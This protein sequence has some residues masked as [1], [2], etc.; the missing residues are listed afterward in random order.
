M[1]S[2]FENFLIKIK[3]WH[4]ILFFFLLNIFFLENFPF[5]HSD[6]AWLSGLSR[7][8]MQT[9][10][11]SSTESFFDLLPRHPHAV[12]IFFHLLQILFIKISGYNIFTFRL[13]S[14]LS[15]SLAAFFF[16]KI[17]IFI[18]KSKKL[19]LAALLI[20]IADIHFIYSSHL[21]RQEAVLLFIFLAALYYF[22]KYN[23][24]KNFKKSLSVFKINNSSSKLNNNSDND[25]TK[26]F[27]LAL[28][29]G[30]AIGFHPN[31]FIIALPFI[32][33]Y[34]CRLLSKK[35]SIKNYLIFGV[36][37]SLIAGLFIYFSFKLD[38]DFISNYSSYGKQL[39]V[40][41][42][43]LVKFKN[44]KNFYLKLYYR[45]SGTYYIPP[46]KFQLI[47]FA[48][49]AIISLFKLFLKKDKI[50]FYLFISLISINI[51]YLIIG[52]YNQ[53]SIIFIFPI[54]YLLFINLI[55]N[56]NLNLKIIIITFLTLIL[57][58]NSVSAI[59]EDSHSNYHDYLT[60]ISKVVDKDTHVLAN[61]N[62]DYYF[63]NGSLFDYRNLAF[64][65]E[66][67][68]SFADYIKKNKIKY[69][70]Y[71]EE[72]D[73]IYS[74][75]PRWNILYG[76]LYPYYSEMKQ[77]INE[78]T[79]LI[80]KFNNSTYAMRIVSKIGQK[81]WTVKIYKINSNFTKDYQQHR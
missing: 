78:K 31:A 18:T 13:I 59:I 1:N 20:L 47:F 29:L 50:N 35:I 54:G 57:I 22:L 70:I 38:P 51:G 66:N 4:I 21:A 71:P 41:D 10:N 68:L 62:A 34:S 45:V 39:G 60:E 56:L 15:S 49:T 25:S 3:S 28:I 80:K 9:G 16:Y 26:D 67:N 40:F 7:Q 48:F 46:I 24:D 8:I 53:T 44:L 58:F 42:S 33:S 75:R 77:F 30:T 19:S 81:N 79:T 72:M 65:K 17:T 37:L 27:I 63:D 73:I 69:I 12:K 36:S 76:N 61:L 5:V 14:L 2:N 52:R 43:F 64:L 23:T 11:L 55:K 6:E 74:S 32:L